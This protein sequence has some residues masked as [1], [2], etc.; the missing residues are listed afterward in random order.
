MKRPTSDVRIVL[1]RYGNLGDLP[2]PRI[3]TRQRTAKPLEELHLITSP[4]SATTPFSGDAGDRTPSGLGT[5]RVAFVLPVDQTGDVDDPLACVDS[6]FWCAGRE[7]APPQLSRPI[8]SR[9]GSLMPSLRIRTSHIGGTSSRIRTY[10]KLSLNGFGDRHLQP[11]GHTR[12][13]PILRTSLLFNSV[14]LFIR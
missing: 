9:V 12:V 4:F 7:F 2:Q 10:V 11:L 8:Y 5:L 1:D 3:N 13:K 14:P 6:Q